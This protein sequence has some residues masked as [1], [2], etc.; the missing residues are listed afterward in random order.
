M[1]LRFVALLVALPALVSAQSWSEGTVVGV[2]IDGSLTVISIWGTG[3]DAT[4]NVP[5]RQLPP[6][7]WT[8]IDLTPFEIPPDVIAV[9]L[10]GM[11]ISSGAP[12]VY[13]GMVAAF[14]PPG[15]V[16]D[17][18]NYQLQAVA[19]LPGGAFR[20]NVTLTVPVR[21]RRFQFWWHYPEAACPMAIHLTLQ[22]YVR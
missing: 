20:Q 22:K 21:N 6:D 17:E 10:Q 4:A 12:G 5:G 14:R 19:S 11:L 9:E 2:P 16:Q 15:S 8:T 13:C 7:R 3:L 18:G 1:R